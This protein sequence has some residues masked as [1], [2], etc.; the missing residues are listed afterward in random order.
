VAGPPSHAPH[1]DATIS[2]VL[3][4]SVRQSLIVL[5]EA[6]DTREQT[7]CRK[8]TGGLDA[9]AMHKLRTWH[10]RPFPRLRLNNFAPSKAKFFRLVAVQWKNIQSVAE[11]VC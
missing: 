1:R 9:S 2:S 5:S 8:N 4:V 7:R 6:V 3:T 11:A 10:R